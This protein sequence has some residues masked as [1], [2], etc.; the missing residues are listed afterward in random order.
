MNK[1]HRKEKSTILQRKIIIA[2]AVVLFILILLA[3]VAPRLINLNKYKGV[4]VAR[5]ETEF[6]RKVE[7]EDIRLT[8]LGGLGI[9]LQGL[10][11]DNRP[12]FL[13]GP[14]I[15]IKRC[16]LSFKLLPLFRGQIRVQRAVLDE[17]EILIERAPTGQYSIDDLLARKIKSERKPKKRIVVASLLAL[18]EPQPPGPSTAIATFLPQ[19]IKIRQGKVRFIDHKINQ[20]QPLTTTFDNLNLSLKAPNGGKGIKLDLSADPYPLKKSRISLKGEIIPPP[21]QLDL[22]KTTLDIE[23]KLNNLSPA[24]FSPYFKNRSFR[25]FIPATINADLQVKGSLSN[26]LALLGQ[27]EL[28]HTVYQGKGADQDLVKLTLQGNTSWNYLKDVLK[29]ERV[30]LSAAEI[31]SVNAHGVLKEIRK[32]PYLDI[33]LN[34]PA[35]FPAKIISRIYPLPYLTIEGRSSCTLKIAGSLNKIGIMGGLDLSENNIEYPHLFQKTTHVP[36]KADFSMVTDKDVLEFKRLEVW[37]DKL[38]LKGTLGVSQ[39]KDPMVQ[40]DMDFTPYDLAGSATLFPFLAEYKLGGVAEGGFSLN[41]KIRESRP[42]DIDSEVYLKGSRITIP[43]IPLKIK[44]LEK[45]TG[46]IYFAGNSLNFKDLSLQAGDSSFSFTTAKWEP[47]KISFDLQGHLLNLDELTFTDQAPPQ[48]QQLASTEPPPPPGVPTPPKTDEKRGYPP[49]LY[50]YNVKGKIREDKVKVRGIYLK[51]LATNIT[52]EGGKLAWSEFSARGFDGDIRSVGAIDFNK[53]RAE[54][55]VTVSLSQLNL[56]PLLDSFTSPSKALSGKLSSDFKLAGK[57][58]TKDSIHQELT[59][60]GDFHI[61]QGRIAQLNIL[62]NLMPKGVLEIL[63]RWKKGLAKKATTSIPQYT[64]FDTLSGKWNLAQAKIFFADLLMQSPD[65]S[66]STRGMVGLDQSLNLRGTGLL[67]PEKTNQLIE[68]K[69]R[70]YLADQQGRLE[71]PFT[72]LGTIKEPLVTPDLLSLSRRGLKA[73]KELFKGKNEEQLKKKLG[74][75]VEKIIE[76][77]LQGH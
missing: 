58:F 16:Q 53:D 26:D 31:V 27:M 25:H 74:K 61:V 49:F 36:F 13:P 46:S 34:S 7:L 77:I 57:G 48:T 45:I 68:E 4:I 39:F 10:Q 18:Y 71:I 50:Q 29:L 14:F 73:Y 15:K 42:I 40:A 56:I 37:L 67:S 19:K 63:S 21:G 54:Y 8:I 38:N 52:L 12:G 24:L 66:I 70:P 44:D 23:I 32:L 65:L 47:S 41:G 59:G 35:F 33:T 9:E 69:Y 28:F 55:Q 3:A 5:L 11:I 60:T 72:I 62:K 76:D 43:W 20:P 64:D 17:P 22:K 2:G 1:G 51:D 75:E 6:N 30:S